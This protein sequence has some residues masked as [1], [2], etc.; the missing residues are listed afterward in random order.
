MGF[1]EFT[2]GPA[3]G[4]TR[5]LNPSYAL[6]THPRRPSIARK[7]QSHL[8]VAGGIVGP[9][10]AHLDE[11]EKMHRLLDQSCDFP[12]RLGPDRLDGL[13]ALSERDF[14]LALALDEYGLLDTHRT[15]AQLLPHIGLDGRTVWQFLVK[16]QINFLPRYF[17]RQCAHRRIGYLVLRIVPRSGRHMSSEPAFDLRDAVAALRRHHEGRSE[18]DAF[19]RLADEAE[20]VRLGHKVDL[21]DDENFGCC[22]DICEFCPDGHGFVIEP[23]LGIDNQ[24][25]DVG[26][27]SAAP[28]DCHHGT[29][30]PA[31]RRKDAGR[32]DENQLGAAFDRDT[33]DDRPRGLHLGS[34]D[35]NL[36]ADHRVDESRFS[37]IGSPDDRDETT[38]LR[39]SVLRSFVGSPVHFNRL[40]PLGRPFGSPL[41]RPLGYPLG[42]PRE[43]AWR[44]PPPARRRAWSAPRPRPASIQRGPRQPGIPDRGAVRCGRSHDRRASANPAP[45][46]IPAAQ[47]WDRARGAP[48]Y[49][50]VPPIVARPRRPRPRSRHRETPLPPRLRRRRRGSRCA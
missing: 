35:R 30:E 15:V 16:P 39:P 36:A 20:E 41:G 42:R 9:A 46:P 1:A 12:A 25:D 38:T 8:A 6:R 19:V 3:G 22:C 26:V 28:C 17:R 18:L 11:Q 48:A 7:L 43:S 45:A 32:V 24:R 49:A 29:V 31:A 13:A 47:S 33:A 21:V 50:G 23:A 44:R 10:L 2:I 27:V 40:L 5:W 37:D 34:D 14:S 4:R